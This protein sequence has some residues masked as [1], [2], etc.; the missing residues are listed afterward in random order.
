[1]EFR[2]VSFSYQSYERENPKRTG[3]PKVKR[4]SD[5]DVTSS[6]KE[7][8]HYDSSV[9]HRTPK[10]GEEEG[11]LCWVLKD[12]SFKIPAGSMC[13]VVGHSGAGKSTL[14]H[15]LLR[16]YD[17]CEGEILIDGVDIRDME[18]EQIQSDLFGVVPQDCVVVHDTIYENLLLARP[19]ATQEE[20]V[21][22][23]KTANIYSTIMNDYPEGFET[24][25]G[26]EGYRLSGGEKQRL[27]IARAVLKDPKMLILDEATSSLDSISE[28]EI[29]KALEPLWTGAKKGRVW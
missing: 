20:V 12:V 11:G 24:V 1:V 26:A 9:F 7:I 16:M 17:V 15:L 27:A 21:H 4:S 8:Q 13:A 5:D 19:K 29:Q 2:N 22:A 28:G 25:V 18:L 10:E 6:G 14:I 23:C 3:L